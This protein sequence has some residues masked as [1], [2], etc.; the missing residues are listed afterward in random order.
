MN[1]IQ[2]KIL[3]EYIWVDACNN[4]RFKTKII[5]KSQLPDYNNIITVLDD[6]N[7]DG[8]STGQAEGRDSVVLIK[9][10]ALYLNPFVSYIESYLVMC[11][12]WNKD[13]TPHSTNRIVKL[14]ETYSQR[15]NQFLTL[16]NNM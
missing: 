9:P 12:C 14:V 13:E 2:D 7:F 3:L 8:S 1:K 11:D 10:R 15:K 5:S 4:P 16:C 6:W